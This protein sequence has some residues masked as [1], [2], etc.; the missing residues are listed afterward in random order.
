[1]NN[2]AEYDRT[3]TIALRELTNFKKFAQ[4]L[5]TKNNNRNHGETLMSKSEISDTI[6]LLQA[7]IDQCYAE[8]D[9]LNRALTALRELEPAKPKPLAVKDIVAKHVEPPAKP[10]KQKPAKKPVQPVISWRQQVVDLLAYGGKTADQ[11]RVALLNRGANLKQVQNALYLLKRA[12][13]VTLE[14]DGLYYTAEEPK[15][16][17]ETVAEGQE[18]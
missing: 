12:G 2:R 18:Q 9:I 17:A 16:E 15:A 6:A 11:I 14:E 3:R 10:V 8:V 1:M 5:E 13:L 7:R 4:N